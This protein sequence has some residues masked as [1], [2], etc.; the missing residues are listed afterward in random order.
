MG[1]GKLRY[2]LDYPN[3]CPPKEAHTVNHD[4]WLY[5]ICVCE[6]LE[7]SGALNLENFIPVWEQ[8]RFFPPKKECSAKAISFNSSSQACWSL[9]DDY[10]NI[11]KKV[12]KVAINQACGLILQS[13]KSTHYNLWDYS[14]PDISLA[15]GNKWKEVV[16]DDSK[17]GV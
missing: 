10:P 6:Q 4:I 14:N 12:I 17:A 16:R 8:D 13:N 3:Q 9:I 2:G 5:R 1:K 11:G 7:Q 15:I